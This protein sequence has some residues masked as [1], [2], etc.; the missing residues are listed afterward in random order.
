LSVG[1]TSYSRRMHTLSRNVGIGL[2]VGATSYSRRMHTLSRNVGI[3][4]PVDATSCPRRMQPSAYQFACRVV[5]MCQATRCRIAAQ[6]VDSSISPL[7]LT[8]HA[9]SRR[10][11]AHSALILQL[12]AAQQST[13]KSITGF[14]AKCLTGR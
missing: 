12:S 13:V 6:T 3:G 4:L 14:I 11:T 7:P 2:S 5:S 9:L 1:A 10:S 8:A